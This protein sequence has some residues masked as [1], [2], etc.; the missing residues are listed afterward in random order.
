MDRRA[1]EAAGP[2]ADRFY[3]IPI[4][5]GGWGDRGAGKPIRCRSKK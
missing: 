3:R 2:E 4:D 1:R 5:R